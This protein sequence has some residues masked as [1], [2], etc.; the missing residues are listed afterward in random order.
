MTG[1]R[2]GERR[3]KDEEGLRLCERSRARTV[4]HDQ[5]TPPVYSR[6][7]S[8]DTS[9]PAQAFDSPMRAAQPQIARPRRWRRAPAHRGVALPRAPR[10]ALHD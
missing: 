4:V 7:A 2:V 3:Q 8:E 9:I 5:R 1:I 6:R 10:V